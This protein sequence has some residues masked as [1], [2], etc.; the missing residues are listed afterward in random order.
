MSHI[1]CNV[2]ENTEAWG[3]ERCVSLAWVVLLLLDWTDPATQACPHL[4]NVTY[5]GASFCLVTSTMLLAIPRGSTV[6]SVLFDSEWL[7]LICNEP[8]TTFYRQHNKS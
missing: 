7:E 3:G 4:L 8:V 1:I 2:D 6:L 5:E